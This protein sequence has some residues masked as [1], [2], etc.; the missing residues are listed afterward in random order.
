MSLTGVPYIAKFVI[1]HLSIVVIEKTS[2]LEEQSFEV[3]IDGILIGEISLPKY[4]LPGIAL[5][6]SYVAL[7]GGQCVYIGSLTGQNFQNF[8]QEDVI[9]TVYPI[10]PDQWCMVCETS[11]LIWDCFVG[12]QAKYEHN[13]V[14]MNSWWKDDLLIIEDFEGKKLIF[15]PRDLSTFL[16]PESTIN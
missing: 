4:Y 8:Q 14:I 2:S 16:N 11:V 3:Q 10:G 12:I 15:N 5:N 13:E 6:N 1:N 7:W 9:H